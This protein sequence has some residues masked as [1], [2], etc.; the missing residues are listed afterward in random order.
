[1]RT[2]AL[3]VALAM[4]AAPATAF[5]HAPAAIGA[6]MPRAKHASVRSCETLCCASDDGRTLRGRPAGQRQGPQHA[7]RLSARHACPVSRA[8]PPRQAVALRM[9]EQSTQAAK[10]AKDEKLLLTKQLAEEAARAL[11]E[12]ELAQ[13]K[14]SA[15][16]R[17]RGQQ[18]ITLSRGS[19]IRAK[20]LMGSVGDVL[21]K[22]WNSVLAGRPGDE[23]H[24]FLGLAGD[25]TQVSDDERRERIRA[26]FSKLDTDGSGKIDAQ[27]LDAGLKDVLGFDADEGTVAQLMREID[28]DGDGEIDVEELSKVCLAI[29]NKAE[30]EAMT[31][32]DEAATL[33]AKAARTRTVASVMEAL[34][35]AG[36]LSAE[37]FPKVAMVGNATVAAAVLSQLKQE[38]KIAL[39]DSAP[40]FFQSTGAERMKA[41][42]GMSKPEEDLG[43]AVDDFTRFRYQGVSFLGLSGGFALLVAGV[44]GPWWNI[45][46]TPD[47]LAMYGYATLLLNVV[48]SVLGPR[49]DQWNTNRLMSAVGD[50]D[51]RWLRRQ[52]GRFVGAY[53]CGVPVESIS[54][55]DS[56]TRPEI[57]IFSR[58]TGNVDLDALRVAAQQAQAASS[59][60]PLR[61]LGLSKSEVDRQAIIQMFGLVAEYRR[62]GKASFGYKFFRELDY[63]LD[64]A[65]E[66]F[67][68][69]AKQVQA[70]F[71]VTMAYQLLDRHPYAF[72]QVLEGLREGKTAAEC[73][74]LFEAALAPD[75]WVETRAQ[76]APT[77][78][79]EDEDEDVQGGL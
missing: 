46:L 73:I 44:E 32:A 60:D 71:G 58:K 36:G 40:R 79:D 18:S 69:Q 42:T 2:A 17:E 26:L 34:E 15:M 49:L 50:G 11:A 51:D 55:E 7:P 16:R 59:P 61:D 70:R 53:L 54:L 47:R 64:F 68:R 10:D 20:Q 4:A 12:A 23:A 39:W 67:T 29:M 9:G 57:L 38:G 75:D 33:A 72:E 77:A 28:A 19:D 1:M 66:P 6:G 65:Q 41:V 27:E 13:Q 24:D 35:G 78:A 62:Y 76:I 25:M 5:L 22:T 74:A 14:A 37:S 52:A 30:A 8:A 31:A 45:G 43:L 3:A 63:Q 56:V 21:Y 48:F